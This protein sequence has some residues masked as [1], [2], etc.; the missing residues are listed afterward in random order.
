MK[1]KGNHT[2]LNRICFCF[3][4]CIS[5]HVYSC[6]INYWSKSL[7]SW[8]YKKKWG[9]AQD[10]CTVMHISPLVSGLRS[11]N[12]PRVLVNTTLNWTFP[13]LCVYLNHGVTHTKQQISIGNQAGRYFLFDSQRLKHKR[14][15]PHTCTPTHNPFCLLTAL[16][17]RSTTSATCH[18][19]THESQTVR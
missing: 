8:Q 16:P 18:L 14:T 2:I 17:K 13:G 6:S 19:V 3:T 11:H 7:F 10:F 4:C 9:V 12:S 1:N 5:I 15:Y